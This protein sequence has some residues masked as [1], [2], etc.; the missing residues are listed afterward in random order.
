LIHPSWN[1]EWFAIGG[2]VWNLQDAP[3]VG[4]TVVL[5]GRY[6]ENLVEL[7]VLS[8]SATVYGVSG[9]EFVLENHRVDSSGL[10]WIQLENE[11]G[12]PISSKTYLDTS[13]SC[14]ANLIIVNFKQVR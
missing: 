4:M 7:S 11:M 14:Q 2:Q 6:G 5:G 8:G 9:Y 10:L 12:I 1:C 3:K 13:S